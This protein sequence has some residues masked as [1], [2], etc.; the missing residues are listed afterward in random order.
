[1]DF[2]RRNSV[3]GDWRASWRAM[4]SAYERGRARAIG[5][6]NF[7]KADFTQLLAFARL[8]P[9]AHKARAEL[10]L[11]HQ[12]SISLSLSLERERFERDSM[13]LSL[14]ALCVC[15]VFFFTTRNFS[16]QIS[17]EKDS[18]DFGGGELD[19]PIR[20]FRSF[21]RLARV[22]FHLRRLSIVQ[23]PFSQSHAILKHQVVQSWMDP[24]RQDRA[25]RE[26]LRPLSI[27]NFKALEF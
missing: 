13:R 25:L 2:R 8:G 7:D 24:Y 23:S 10:G 11:N 22:L 5:V 21:Q 17:L 15:F 9:H 26:T 16:P 27:A 3:E 18:F 14:S 4:E 20:T 19:G 12:V 1:M 6:S